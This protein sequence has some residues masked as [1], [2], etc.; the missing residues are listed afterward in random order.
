MGNSCTERSCQLPLWMIPLLRLAGIYNILFG[1]WAVGWPGEWF[2]IL[3]MEQ[4]SY[5][6]LWQGI[7]M[8]VGVYG[9]GY[10][11][12]S[13][14]PLKHW[15]IILVGFLG[16]LLGPLGFAWAASKGE[17]PWAAGWLIL[18]NDIIWLIPFGIILW[19]AGCLAV[20]RPVNGRPMGLETAMKSFKLHSGESLREAS[21]KETLAIVFLRHFGCTFTRQLLRKLETMQKNADSQGARLILVHMLQ[22]GEE[23]QYVGS[24][25]VSRISDPW[26]DL[27]RAFG[28]GKGTFIELFGPRVWYRGFVAVFK[29]CG[30]GHLAGDGLQ[31]PGAFLVKDG[32]II[33]GQK[34]ASAADLPDVEGL[35]TS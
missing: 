32:K 13:A 19:H 8:I 15:P 23:T 22:E 20:G 16:K 11:C 17:L 24:G 14:A 33:K 30:V 6:F 9:I 34:A 26:C 1:I 29:G 18:F 28:L 31:M 5:P 2:R 10:V 27:Y 35:F 21:E 12:A 3:G 25:R 7:G 4:P